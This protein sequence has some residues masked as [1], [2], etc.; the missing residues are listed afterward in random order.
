M[1]RPLTIAHI[2][3]LHL[4]PEFKRSNIRNTRSLLDHI[5]RLGVDHLVVTG[6]IAANGSPSDFSIARKMFEG[7]GLLDPRKLSVVIG[8]HDIYGGV[9]TAEDILSF[10]ARCRATDYTGKVGE[11]GRWFREAFTGC[12]GGPDGELF[13]F[14]KDLGGVVL[15][16]INSIAPYSAVANPLGS[17]GI[18]SERQLNH[19]RRVLDSRLFKHKQRAV[20]IHHH[21]HKAA[22]KSSSGLLGNVWGTLES[23]TMKLR[24]KKALLEFFREMNIDIVLHGHDHT[25]MEYT[26]KDLLFLNA[27]GSVQGPTPGDLCV[28]FVRADGQGLKTELHRIPSSSVPTFPTFDALLPPTL[29]EAEPPARIS[30]ETTPVDAAA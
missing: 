15:V 12:I 6:D 8:N 20:L 1:T 24:G 13:P 30:I 17:N 16:G 21:F 5:A 19:L 25:T 29:L 4:S 26:R 27:G 10:P 3:D 23:Q 18:V 7:Y 22:G 2:S 11:F 28:N 9:N 14:V